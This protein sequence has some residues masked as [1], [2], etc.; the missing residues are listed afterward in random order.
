VVKP[1]P[2][3]LKIRAAVVNARAYEVLARLNEEDRQRRRVRFLATKALISVMEM[4]TEVRSMSAADRGRF[5][6]NCKLARSV[7]RRISKTGV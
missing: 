4:Q 3:S 2:I 6:L 1:A 7:L 5:E